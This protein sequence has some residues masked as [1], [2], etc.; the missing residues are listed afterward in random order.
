MC[1][2]AGV[3]DLSRGSSA[4]ALEHVA[5]EMVD[6]LHRRGPDD[7]GAWVD[8]DAG[9][10]LASRRLAIVDLSPA[11]HQPMTSACERFTVAYNGEVYNHVDIR[12]ELEHAG[13]RF[14]GHSDTEVLLAAVAAWDLD[15]ALERCNGM[16]AFALWDARRRLLHLVRD[17]LGEKP[18]YYARAGDHV[19]FGSELKALRAYP[20]FRGVIDRDALALYLRF[21]YVPSPHT[22]YRDATK[23]APGTA[24]TLRAGE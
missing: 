20:S 3:L 19:V 12:R 24:L 23:L 21:S 18:L 9:V 14:R 5:L 16:F 10:A 15:R 1:G 17:R 6:T 22:I 13:H 7:R 4:D 11:G 2:I 8:A